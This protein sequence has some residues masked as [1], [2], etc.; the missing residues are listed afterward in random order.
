MDW[1]NVNGV[2]TSYCSIRLLV[3]AG[4]PIKG[5]TA[6][7]YKDVGEIPDVMGAS[8]V[9]LGWTRGNNRSEGDIEL[10]QSE[11][12]ELLPKITAA[13][14]TGYMETIWPVAVTYAEAIQP[15]KTKTDMLPFVRF[16]SGERSHAKGTD[17]L[18]IKLQMKILPQIQWHGLYVAQ[19]Q[20]VL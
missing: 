14:L 10:L 19:R 8:A 9:P 6:I 1:P 17:A 4:V 15:Q 3:G 7:N 11:W 20:L 5:V 16:H 12:D 2:E 13:G 18:T